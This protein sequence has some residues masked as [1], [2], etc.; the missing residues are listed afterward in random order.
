M[1]RLRNAI[2]ISGAHYYRIPVGGLLSV[3]RGSRFPAKSKSVPPQTCPARLSTFQYRNAPPSPSLH[4][5]A[6][7]VEKMV[8]M[9]AHSTILQTPLTLA[10]VTQR[11]QQPDGPSAV[12]ARV[13]PSRPHHALSLSPDNIDHACSSGHFANDYPFV[14]CNPMPE[15]LVIRAKSAQAR[16][17]AFVVAGE[18][19]RIRFLD[20]VS[21]GRAPSSIGP[22]SLRDPNLAVFF[23]SRTEVS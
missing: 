22:P 14:P 2:P 3:T 8:N 21:V 6:A 5:T 1:S 12:R 23:K 13:L 7:L 19:R 11:P 4:M 20:N 16:A 15:N 9:H 18:D 17:D 10:Q